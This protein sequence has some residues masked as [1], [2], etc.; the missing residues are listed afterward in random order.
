MRIAVGWKT[1]GLHV[2]IPPHGRLDY[3]PAQGI[4]RSPCQFRFMAAYEDLKALI[5]ALQV[6]ANAHSSKEDPLLRPFD[7]ADGRCVQRFTLS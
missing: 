7:L 5:G 3:L 4:V 1:A 2:V 6:S